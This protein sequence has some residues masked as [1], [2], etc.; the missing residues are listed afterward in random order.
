ML[1]GSANL[2]WL[3]VSGDFG[4]GP[5]V[6]YF[7]ALDTYF[8]PADV[9]V[10]TPYSNWAHNTNGVVYTGSSM[11]KSYSGTPAMAPCEFENLPAEP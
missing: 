2:F 5:L 9:F 4:P 11:S 10:G 3:G 8:L 6:S 7:S 1:K